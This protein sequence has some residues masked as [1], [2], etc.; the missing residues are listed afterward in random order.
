METT[1]IFVHEGGTEYVYMFLHLNQE[2]SRR[3]Q[4]K[5]WKSL[6]KLGCKTSQILFYHS[7]LIFEA[8]KY[9]LNWNKNGSN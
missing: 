5:Q 6:K 4:K 8:Y 3:I 9:I 7:I 1:C 2:A